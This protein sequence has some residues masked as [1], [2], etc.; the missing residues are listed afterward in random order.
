MVASQH[1]KQNPVIVCSFS[2]YIL[3]V[4]LPIFDNTLQSLGVCCF[5]LLLEN[6]FKHENKPLQVLQFSILFFVCDEV[7]KEI[8]LLLNIGIL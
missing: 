5:I 6:N 3:D 4:I 8:N 7:Q 2:F 1:T